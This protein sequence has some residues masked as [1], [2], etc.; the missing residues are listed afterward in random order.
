MYTNYT[1]LYL[2]KKKTVYYFAMP[3]ALLNKKKQQKKNKKTIPKLTVM[4]THKMF[5]MRALLLYRNSCQI[6][7]DNLLPRRVLSFPKPFV[8]PGLP[9][10]KKYKENNIHR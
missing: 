5:C 2:Y 6:L 9:K 7:Y 10:K 1:Y 4:N 3:A 8:T